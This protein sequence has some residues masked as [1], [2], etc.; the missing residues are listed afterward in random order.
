MSDSWEEDRSAFI[1]GEIGGAVIELVAE[2]V[3]IDRDTIVERLEDKRKSVGN[4]I[5]KGIL[6]D[7][8]E[9]VRE[10]R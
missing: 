5:H 9:F 10:G 3:V 2:G 7:A 6:R 8:A 1:A 4:T